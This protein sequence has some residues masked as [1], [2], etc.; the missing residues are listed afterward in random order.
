MTAAELIELLSA[1]PEDT[2]VRFTYRLNDHSRTLVS[3]APSW[4]E[5]GMGVSKESTYAEAYGGYGAQMVGEDDEMVEELEGEAPSE[6]NCF[7]IP[8]AQGGY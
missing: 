1:L 4:V 7:L 3:Y 8:L 2:E 5:A 6:P